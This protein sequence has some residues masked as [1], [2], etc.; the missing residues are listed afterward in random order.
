VE[1]LVAFVEFER[2]QAQ[3]TPSESKADRARTFGPVI[4][5][6]DDAIARFVKAKAI[7]KVLVSNPT[8]N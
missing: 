5:I 2:R 6:Y 7:P 4:A 1:A 3:A 8:M